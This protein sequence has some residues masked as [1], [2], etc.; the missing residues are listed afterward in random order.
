[1]TFP[2]RTLH[3]LWA[4]LILAYP[5]TTQY[6]TK[7]EKICIYNGYLIKGVQLM[8]NWNYLADFD[9]SPWPLLYSVWL[10]HFTGK[11]MYSYILLLLREVEHSVF[12]E[13]G[14]S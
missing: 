12:E 14:K 2:F 13:D 7:H 4:A 11:R 10:F 9:S 5:C 3:F 6:F 1:M 8:P